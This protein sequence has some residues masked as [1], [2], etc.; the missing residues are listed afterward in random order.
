MNAHVNEPVVPVRSL[1]PEVPEKL[2]VAIDRML[3]KKRDERYGSPG[4]VAEALRPFCAGS[5][6]VG[7]LGDAQRAGP[8][9][10]AVAVRP[11]VH[12]ARVSKPA[13]PAIRADAT[14][15]REKVAAVAP[16]RPAAPGGPSGGGAVE[17]FNAY[18]VWLSIP[19]AE[20]PP[21][22]YRLLGLSLFEANREAIESAA[23]G[24]TMLL[25]TFALGKHMEPIAGV[26]QRG[27]ESEELPVDPGEKGGLR[28][29]P[30]ANWRPRNRSARGNSP[31]LLGSGCPTC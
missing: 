10:I 17:K 18:H 29:P 1:R 21:N 15:R 25:R 7:L 20:Q 13:A 16:S 3:A 2:G 24:R 30:A 14:D 4:E 27:T 23:V 22:H 8:K 26:A 9:A 19:P 12:T 6:L 5:D 31:L 11:G 28:R